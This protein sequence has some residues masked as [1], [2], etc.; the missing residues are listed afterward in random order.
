MDSYQALQWVGYEIMSH[1]RNFY[2]KIPNSGNSRFLIMMW[3]CNNSFVPAL[4]YINFILFVSI[5]HCRI[6][7]IMLSSTVS[8]QANRGRVCGAGHPARWSDLW[9]LVLCGHER[10]SDSHKLHHQMDRCECLHR[11]N[12][13]G[14]IAAHCITMT[15]FCTITCILIYQICMILLRHL[16]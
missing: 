1:R 10:T 12:L 14:D 4:W 6:T 8:V 3:H 16:T 5:K 9:L 7:P 11:Q 15:K 2:N 13:D